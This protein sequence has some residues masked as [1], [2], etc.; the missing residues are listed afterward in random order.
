VVAV[1]EEL[2]VLH[3]GVIILLWFNS[4]SIGT[5]KNKKKTPDTS[6]SEQDIANKLG[7]TF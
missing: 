2:D 6:T 5:W 7:H 4:S 3:D 1:G